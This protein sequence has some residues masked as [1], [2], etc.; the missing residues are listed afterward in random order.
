MKSEMTQIKNTQPSVLIVILN[1]K[2]YELTL[3]LIEQLKKLSYRNYEI[4]VIDNCSPNKS[5]KVLSNNANRKSYHFVANDTNAGYAA[6]NNIGIRYA[7][8]NGFTYTWI[9]NNDVK[10]TDTAIL[11]KLVYE[12]EKRENVACVGPEIVDIDGYITAPY[13]NQ[14]TFKSMTIGILKERKKRAK[15][16]GKS[17]EVYRVFGCCILLKNSFMKKVNCMDERTFLYC[18]EEILSER[19]KKV[20]GISYYCAE[21]NIVHLESMTVKKEHGKRSIKR[22]QIMLKSLDLYLKEYRK[23]GFL[24]RLACEIIRGLIVFVRG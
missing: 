16:I 20:G 14:P 24:E 12:A 8:K 17:G 5:K 19:L 22:V 13:C 7:I 23:F 18:E 3:D 21:T 1:Y 6:G 15:N 2:T 11:E 10:I 9:L 4:M